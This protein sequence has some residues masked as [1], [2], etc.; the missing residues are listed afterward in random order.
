MLA[1]RIDEIGRQRQAGVEVVVVVAGHLED[2][3]P[4]L[5]HGLRAGDRVVGGERDELRA[6]HPGRPVT[7]PQRGG[8]QGDAH[9]SCRVARRPAADEAEGGGDLGGLSRNE[10]EDGTEE[11]RGLVEVVDRLGDRDMI[12]LRERGRRVQRMPR[13]GGSRRARLP[14]PSES[15][16]NRAVPSGVATE[17]RSVSSGRRGRG[18]FGAS[19]RSARCIDEAG[20]E[21]ST[22]SAQIDAVAGAI[23]RCGARLS[24]TRASPCSHSCT[25]MRAMLAGVGEPERRQGACDERSRDLVDRE[26]GEREAAEL[27]EPA[28]VRRRESRSA[29]PRASRARPPPRRARA[30]SA[31]RRWRRAAGPPAGRRR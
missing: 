13:P 12:D 22:A 25:G 29:R 10:S 17:L 30:W 2:R 11:Q 23:D 19:S 7:P 18:S 1:Q 20:S 14:S 8:A 24:R 27:G 3:R 21:L 4:A 5:A 6:R 28:A 9:A 26:L 16:K 31:S 15:Q